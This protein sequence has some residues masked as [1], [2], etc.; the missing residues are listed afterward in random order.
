M[1][2]LNDFH[3]R[4]V[5][6]GFL[7]IHHR[8]AKLE[9]AMAGC[10]RSSPLSEFV[11]DISPAEIKVVQDYCSRVRSTMLACLEQC[12]IPLE[13]HRTSLRWALQT[14]V[15]F[16]GIAV[17]ELGPERM[18]GY[19]T[20]DG[21]AQETLRK[22]QRELNRL[23]D[24]F[25]TYLRQG[26]GQ[27]LAQRME[28]LG[29][30]PLNV[31]TLRKLSEV[32][33]RWQLFEFEPLL[34]TIVQRLEAP[35]FEIAVFGRVNSGKSS[36]LNYLARVDV[37]PVGVTPVTAV[38]TRLRRGEKPSALI[39]FAE[40]PP[41]RIDV[42]ELREYASEQGNP[43]NGKHVTGIEVELPSPRLRD[44]VVLVDTPGVGSLALAG[45][46][47]TYAYLPRCDLS[48][49][50][51]DAAA[52][53]NQEDL[54]LVRLLYEA[55]IAVHVLL[56]K[57]DRLNPADQLRTLDYIRQQ[58]RENL[59]VQPPVHAVSSVGAS[60]TLLDAWFQDD[61]DPLLAH[62][63]ELAEASLQRKIAHLRES[64]VAAL[65]TML[66]RRQA[67]QSASC[68]P[69]DLLQMQYVLQE[70]DVA[71]RQAHDFARDKLRDESLPTMAI[72][73]QTAQAIADSR[74]QSTGT[75]DD[76]LGQAVRKCLAGEGFAAYKAIVDLQ[77][78][79]A[80]TL[81]KLDM[82][83]PLAR[84]DVELV[85]DFKLQGL[86]EADLSQLANC[87]VGHSPWWAT[88]SRGAAVWALQHTMERQN[89]VG[90]T[91]TVRRHRARLLAWFL[92][93]MAEL[94]DASESQVR[95]VRQ[96]MRRAA[97]IPD[98]EAGGDSVQDLREDLKQLQ[99]LTT[100]QVPVP[101][102]DKQSSAQTTTGSPV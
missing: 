23:I 34:E 91:E 83:A 9:G 60:A 98:H 39:R 85:R 78:A 81:E 44:G 86:P 55:G 82:S 38:P 13:V 51:V 88:W 67:K 76:L 64:I 59:G 66:A 70:A 2:Q 62:H 63:R 22:I 68:S 53:L 25:S 89:A 33:S 58:L 92:D 49:V 95:I 16:V 65:Q 26:A 47:E 74:R 4:S 18:R 30:K 69:A 48:V 75:D 20:L 50:L 12:D 102:P 46:T 99:E 6:A 14:G 94:T 87:T 43:G 36:L 96:Q 61:L 79:L 41:R 57:A 11:Q 24:R 28:R 72:I 7:D 52:T 77:R 19:G 27:D 73:R 21:N 1:G 35:Q 8:L 90:V 40:A 32:I 54:V 5:L 101:P 37:L 45:S 3:R 97:D 29:A 56:S 71:T 93:A 17:D 100:D 31:A 84:L 15:A 80:S 10:D 42:A